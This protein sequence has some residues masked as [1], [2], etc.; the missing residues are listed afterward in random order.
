MNLF[1]AVAKV[2]TGQWRSKR[3]SDCGTRCNVVGHT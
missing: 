3:C 1:C 2:N